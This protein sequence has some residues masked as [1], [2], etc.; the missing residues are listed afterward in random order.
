[1]NNIKAFIASDFHLDFWDSDLT[2]RDDVFW[3]I[4]FDQD[5][6]YDLIILAGD[7]G[8]CHHGTAQARY[9]TFLKHICSVGKPVILIKGNHENYKSQLVNSKFF[10]KSMQCE[11]FS[12]LYYL[13]KEHVDLIINNQKVRIFGATLWTDF[14]NYD[15]LA[16]LEAKMKMYDFGSMIL[17]PGY[18]KFLPEDAFLDHKEALQKMISS[19]QGLSK[20]TR[21]IVVT[22]H[23]PMEKF[24]KDFR[25][26]RNWNDTIEL[27]DYSY[28]SDLSKFIENNLT[29]K[30]D[31]WISG[32]IHSPYEFEEFGIKFISNPYGYG[33]DYEERLYQDP[34]KVLEFN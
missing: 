6:P 33:I 26:K 9:I 21:F 16:I 14:N 4:G 25:K 34:F 17:A 19:S 2:D 24:V 20:D 32:H 11:L 10:L 28:F 18:R 31:Y 12:N 22:H 23:A 1:M 8:Q 15:P 27:L 13:E 7:I 30:P 3:R 29:R 5:D